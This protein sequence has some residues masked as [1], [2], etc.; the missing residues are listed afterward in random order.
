MGLPA[1]AQDYGKRFGDQPPLAAVW[2]GV[3]KGLR[4]LFGAPG[5]V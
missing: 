4:G 3:L 1:A 2:R 5:E